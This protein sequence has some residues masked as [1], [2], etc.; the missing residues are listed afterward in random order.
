VGHGPRRESRAYLGAS[1]R[2]G[3]VTVSAVEGFELDDEPY[4]VF[5]LH[6]KGFVQVTARF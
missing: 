2:F 4:D 6:D 1:A 3:Q 5:G